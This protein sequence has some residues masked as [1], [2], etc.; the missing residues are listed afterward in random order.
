MGTDHRVESDVM[1]EVERAAQEIARRGEAVAMT[2]AGIS[3]DSG[4][5]DFRSPGGLWEEFDPME[6]AT[7]SAFSRDPRRVWRMLS[8]LDQIVHEA[9]P[10]PGHL[11]LARLEELGVLK[12]VV[13]QNVDNLHQR[14]G[15]QKVV[16]F[17][18]NGSRLR[19]LECGGTESADRIPEL[20]MPPECGCGAIYKPDVVFFGEMIPQ[21]PMAEATR[22]AKSCEVVLVVG[23]SA[24]V[25]PASMLPL[26]AK[27]RG[28]LLVE[29]NLIPTEI[30]YACD[31][32]VLASASVSLPLL[33]RMVE[34]FL[35]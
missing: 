26:M 17:H 35:E 33:A 1:A 21:Q 11:G 27:E 13:T 30:T 7:I 20:G 22:L 31:I 16:E 29:F 14:A 24:T 28:A 2:G 23:T 18:G 32:K 10:N 25:A 9:E 12:G 5:P 4:I 8:R 34:K 15:S 19:C 3:V 6:Y